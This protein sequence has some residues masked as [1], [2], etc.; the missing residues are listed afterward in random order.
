MTTLDGGDEL[1]HRGRP[2]EAMA[3]QHT[4]RQPVT[5]LDGGDELLHRGWPA[6]AMAT[7]QSH[8]VGHVTTALHSPASRRVAARGPGA[9]SSS[10]RRAS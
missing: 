1:L 5:T 2:A 9:T 8:R 6:E 10:A 4:V 7:Q 3:T